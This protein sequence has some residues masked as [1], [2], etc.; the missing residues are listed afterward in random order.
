[1]TLTELLVAQARAVVAEA[2]AELAELDADPSSP[3]G[4]LVRAR[5]RHARR[6]AK[7]YGAQAADLAACQA[8]DELSRELRDL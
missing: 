3:I 4:R 6:L 7:A 2:C 8:G 5:A 1:M